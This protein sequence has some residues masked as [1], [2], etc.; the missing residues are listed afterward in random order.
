MKARLVIS[1]DELANWG[2]RFFPCFTRTYQREA[3]LAVLCLRFTEVYV[4]Q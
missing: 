4:V 3:C 2:A 1:A